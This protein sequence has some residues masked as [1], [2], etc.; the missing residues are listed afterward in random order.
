MKQQ[1][2]EWLAYLETFPT[3][4]AITNLEH[5]QLVAKK[6]Q[7]NSFPC[8]VIIVAGTNGKGSCVAFLEKIYLNAGYKTAAYISP[9]II[10]YNE[11]IR[12]N[13]HDVDDNSLCKTFDLIE[14]TRTNINHPTNLSYF[15]FTTLAAL[16]IFKQHHPDI[17]ILEVG[18]GGRL[19]AVNIIDADIAVITTISLDHTQ[20]LGKTRDAIGKEKAGIMRANKPVVCG[21]FDPP[22]IIYKEASAIKAP[23]YCINQDFSFTATNHDW[24][25]QYNSTIIKNLPLTRLPL[26]NAA[27]A[28]MAV[29]LLQTKLSVPTKAIVAGLAQAFLPGR[30]QII[31]ILLENKNSELTPIDPSNLNLGKARSQQAS[32]VYEVI[33]E[34]REQEQQHSINSKCAGYINNRQIILDVAHNP[35]S[36]SLLAHNL[37][38]MSMRGNQT[39]AVVSMLK[40]KDICSS[41]QPIAH[42][43]DKW[44]ISTLNTPR[45]ATQQQL[46]TNLETIGV[47]P[48]KI[49]S[50]T[51]IQE[52]LQQAIA[53]T[54]KNDRIVAFGSFY[55]IAT[56]L[57]IFYNQAPN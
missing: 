12:L 26:Q 22:T 8:P 25:W 33:H 39:V 40:D 37:A 15:E 38:A 49:Q 29:Y 13:G 6:L 34:E 9:H 1:L 44:F 46:R 17:I 4:F 23:L 19:D 27:T 36:T 32:G 54:E 24:T 51:N 10:K 55:V 2:H 21:D 30:L 50:C 31:T 7:I 45:A 18:L 42:L 53:S 57:Q 56:I 11:R 3:G 35:E 48:L 28:L 16:Y 5:V 43:I 20:L 52:A 47:H 14:N 41:L